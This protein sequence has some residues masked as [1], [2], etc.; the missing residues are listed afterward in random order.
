MILSFAL[1]ELDWLRGE[2]SPTYTTLYQ[3]EG[4]GAARE[5]QRKRWG[6][7]RRGKNQLSHQV[8]GLGEN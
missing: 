6:A 5:G 2:I 4:D 7:Q 1:K 3:A 8:V